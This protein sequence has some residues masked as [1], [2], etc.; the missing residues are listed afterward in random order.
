[1]T[2]PGAKTPTVYCITT[3]RVRVPRPPSPVPNPRPAYPIADRRPFNPPRLLPPAHATLFYTCTLDLPPVL[4][5]RLKTKTIPLAAPFP[6]LAR[7]NLAF[8][9]FAAACTLHI[10]GAVFCFAASPVQTL[11]GLGSHL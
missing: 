5:L 4:A 9:F 3:S 10:D 1:M 7:L 8:V 6:P 11:L 2:A